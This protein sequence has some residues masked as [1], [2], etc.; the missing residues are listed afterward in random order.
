MMR[1][2]LQRVTRSVALMLALALPLQ[3]WAAGAW[4][5][6]EMHHGGAATAWQTA[7][8]GG[9]MA[10]RE[11]HAGHGAGAHDHAGAHDGHGAQ[12]GHVGH[13]DHVTGA[14]APAGAAD[15]GGG[16]A[17]PHLAAHCAACASCVGVAAM[18]SPAYQARIVPA[19]GTPV[20]DRSVPRRAHFETDGPERPPRAFRA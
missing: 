4:R 9:V 18:P 2:W 17:S 1:P 3:G 10:P 13:A 5:V 7:V 15:D 6:C 12:Q 16:A 19:H 14:F 8:T 20:V 11:G